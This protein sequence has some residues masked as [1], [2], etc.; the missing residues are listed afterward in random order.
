MLSDVSLTSA[1]ERA[2][3]DLREGARDQRIQDMNDML[4]TVARAVGQD[5]IKSG[6]EGASRRQVRRAIEAA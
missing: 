4:D 5:V 2:C 1:L 6:H 3:A